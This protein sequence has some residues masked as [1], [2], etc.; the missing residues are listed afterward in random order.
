MEQELEKP[1]LQPEPALPQGGLAM[2]GPGERVPMPAGPDT[3]RRQAG[4]KSSN[5]FGL[6]AAAILTAGLAGAIV[7]RGDLRH[8]KPAVPSQPPAVQVVFARPQPKAAAPASAPV[9]RVQPPSELPSLVTS[10]SPVE[11]AAPA[12][13]NFSSPQP[14]FNSE[15]EPAVPKM[16]ALQPYNNGARP[17]QQPGAARPVLPAANR[18]TPRLQPSGGQYAAYPADATATAP[19]SRGVCTSCKS[20]VSGTKTSSTLQ[21]G[22]TYEQ[23]EIGVKYGGVCEGK[24]LYDYANLTSNMT[25]GMKIVTSGGEAWSF[26]LK[27]GE[28]TSIKSST[29]FTSGTFESYRTSEVIN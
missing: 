7:F 18:L 4:G 21:G 19:V 27:P 20:A 15:E 25:I 16:A 9:S 6:A 22:T 3:A 28:K 24:Y 1:E 10:G 5:T 11:T 29:E 17:A 23:H 26:T 13:D 2:P 8:V 14:F 12:P